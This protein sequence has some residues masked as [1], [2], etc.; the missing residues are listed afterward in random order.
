MP[1]LLRRFC[2]SNNL[3]PRC[4]RRRRLARERDGARRFRPMLGG[5]PR[6]PIQGFLGPTSGFLFG[7]ARSFL[8]GTV[9]GFFANIT[10]DFSLDGVR[11]FLGG[12]PRLYSDLL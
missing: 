10:Y 2:T 9:R 12:I 4:E 6:F 1:V 5:F 3:P 8:F 11:T 7:D